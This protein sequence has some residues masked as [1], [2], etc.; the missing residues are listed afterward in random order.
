MNKTS[1]A[2]LVNPTSGLFSALKP[3][4]ADLADGLFGSTAGGGLGGVTL[5]GNDATAPNVDPARDYLT[6]YLVITCEMFGAKQGPGCLEHIG[7][8]YGTGPSSAGSTAQAKRRAAA[9]ANALAPLLH[10]LIKP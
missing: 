9:N 6:G 10:Y 2:H 3:L 5:P 8:G 4:L 7:Q 1:F